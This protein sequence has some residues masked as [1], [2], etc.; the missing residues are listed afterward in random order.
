MEFII[1]SVLQV[2]FAG[3]IYLG[4]RSLIEDSK[5]EK[6]LNFKNLEQLTNTLKDITEKQVQ[7]QHS[8]FQTLVQGVI[9]KSIDEFNQLETYR[10]QTENELRRE[11]EAMKL[12][13][14][15]KIKFDVKPVKKQKKKDTRTL[16]ELM[17]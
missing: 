16:E 8:V 15:A 7:N 9:A 2:L 11:T 4:F 1:I 12:K 10:I 13:E 6:E 3:I 14:Q 17:E 5:T